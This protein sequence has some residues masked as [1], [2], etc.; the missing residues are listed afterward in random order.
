MLQ[1]A[2]PGYGLTVLQSSP[3]L[4][5]PFPVHLQEAEGGSLGSHPNFG[6]AG[7]GEDQAEPG[8]ELREREGEYVLH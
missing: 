7:A 3:V 6:P 8:T 5:D 1:L 4:H 2:Q